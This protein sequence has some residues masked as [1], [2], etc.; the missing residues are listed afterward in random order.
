MRCKVSSWGIGLNRKAKIT[1]LVLEDEKVYG[2][3][4]VAV[5][6]NIGFGGSVDVP[7]HIDS[8]IR[9][10]SLFLDGKCVMEKGKL[11]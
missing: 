1:G 10:P 9:K 11:L 3:C 4:H 7:L 6:N 8:V 2:T 5:G